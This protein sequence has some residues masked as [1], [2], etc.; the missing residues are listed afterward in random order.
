MSVSNEE[1]D[2]LVDKAV[3]EIRIVREERER[4]TVTVKTRK[5][6]IHKD[7][8]HQRLKNIESRIDRKTT[9]LKFSIVQETFL[10]L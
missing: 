7:R 6:G 4:S 8:I 2:D 10:I 1:I 9:N 3:R 5:L